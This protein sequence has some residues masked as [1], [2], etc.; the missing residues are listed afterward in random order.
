M[1]RAL[2]TGRNGAALLCFQLQRIEKFST[3]MN[4]LKFQ[5]KKAL[6]IEFSMLERSVIEVE[7]IREMRKL[8]DWQNEPTLDDPKLDDFD[9][10]EDLNLRRLHDAEVVGGVMSNLA[11]ANALE[12]GTAEGHMTAL[13]AQSA[14]EST[15]YT[16]NIPPEELE[17]GEGGTLT[18]SAVERERIGRFYRERGC[19]NVQQIYAN[20][21]T[22]KPDIGPIGAAF[23]DGCHD[24][25][26]VYNDTCKALEIAQ[27]GSY[28]LWHDFNF[29][30]A[31]SYGWIYEVCVGIEE[32]YRNKKLRGRMYHLRDSWV[33]LY[34]VPPNE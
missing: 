28:I 23:I 31:R 32:L 14:P 13:M 33:G 5:I 3:M 29:G 6:G 22:W 8:F 10:P 18:T 1:R 34:R 21:K 25:E 17:R 9:Y 2:G 30:L 11:G 26:Y 20:S 4:R 15:I 27:P 19:E 24:A 12:I 16:M 7:N